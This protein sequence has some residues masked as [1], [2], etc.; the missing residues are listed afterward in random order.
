MLFGCTNVKKEILKT[1]NIDIKI[2]EKHPPKHY[3]AYGIF[4]GQDTQILLFSQKHCNM[5][6]KVGDIIQGEKVYYIDGTIRI[7]TN[8]ELFCN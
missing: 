1:E 7:K 4:I 5:K 2:T 3:R 6:A 8:R